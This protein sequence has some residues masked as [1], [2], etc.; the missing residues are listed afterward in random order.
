MAQLLIFILCG[1]INDPLYYTG[2]AG[3][4]MLVLTAEAV[5]NMYFQPGFLIDLSQCGLNFSFSFF[6][7]SLGKSIISF[8]RL[9]NDVLDPAIAMGENHSATGFFILQRHSNS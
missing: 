2:F 6:H 4:R 5:E 9:D 8:E 3:D 1:K 7:V